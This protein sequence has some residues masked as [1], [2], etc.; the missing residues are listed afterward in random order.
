MSALAAMEALVLMRPA[1]GVVQGGTLAMVELVHRRI[2]E[3]TELEA[4]EVAAVAA[5]KPLILRLLMVLIINSSTQGE[6]GPGAML[7][8]LVL[9]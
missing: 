9:V 3:V 5:T 2:L 6:G 1:A 7:A 4:E 8:C